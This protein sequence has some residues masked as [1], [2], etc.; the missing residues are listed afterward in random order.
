M[1][2]L[3]YGP[4]PVRESLL[5]G[6]RIFHRLLL[7]QGL[8]ERGI[9]AEILALASEVGTAVQR[10]PRQELDRLG[11]SHQGLAAEVSPYPYADW[12]EMLGTAEERREPPLLLLL[13]LLQDPQNVGTLLRTAEAVAVHGV[14]LQER[15]AVGIT[16]AVVN[17]SAGGVEHLLVA[18]VTNLARTMK[19]LQRASLWLAGV[20][21]LLITHTGDIK[22]V[23][24]NNISKV[25]FEPTI[26]IDDKGYPVC[27]KSIE[28]LSLLEQ[29][30]LARP[31]DMRETIYRAFLDPQRMKDVKA[32]E[33]EFHLSM[34]QG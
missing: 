13:D 25:T 33:K 20:E 16:P 28:A 7:A 34:K 30:L 18:R 29:K 22:L 17:S 4:H 21:N 19:A 12:P 15:R 24:I 8:Q 10:V 6:Q 3:L 5:A 11:V 2:E 27:D 1:I 32:L 23:D 31:I 26:S 14:I 9:V